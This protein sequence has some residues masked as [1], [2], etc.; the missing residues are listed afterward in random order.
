MSV[1]VGIVGDLAFFPAGINRHLTQFNPANYSELAR[2]DILVGNLEFP[3]SLEQIPYAPSSHRE[4]LAPAKAVDVLK[5]FRF[6]ALTLANNHIADWGAEGISHTKRMLTEIGVQSCGAGVNEK[7]SRRPLILAKNGIVLGILAYCKNGFFTANARRMGAAPIKVRTIVEDIRELRPKVDHVIVILHWGVEFSSYPSPEDVGVAHALIESGADCIIGHH[8]H[9]VQGMEIYSGKP[10]FYS[11]GSFVYNPRLE[12]VFV[13]KKIKERLTSIA[14][15]IEFSKEAVISWKVLPFI[16]TGVSI[17]P[18]MMSP[19][20][21]SEFE[22]HFREI[23][24]RIN[25]SRWFYN[26]AASNLVHRE[27]RTIGSLLIS[28]RG[29]YV[30]TLIR[31]VRL[32]HLKMIFGKYLFRKARVNG[33]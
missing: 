5:R 24:A 26:E 28:S 21:R 20:E 16:N 17:F 27:L 15:E 10:I 13:D 29:L 8:P 12:R 14:V 1:K 31:M 7:E 19:A 25:D 22:K 2:A 4:Y 23:S 9:V 33:S 30:F 32:R 11:L 3:F 18:V 6:D